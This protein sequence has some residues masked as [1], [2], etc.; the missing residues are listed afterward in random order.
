MGITRET[1]EKNNP[2]QYKTNATATAKN[3]MNIQ[4]GKTSNLVGFKWLHWPNWRIELAAFVWRPFKSKRWM[5]FFGVCAAKT[6][7]QPK[8]KQYELKRVPSH[9]FNSIA[10]IE[11]P[12][13]HSIVHLSCVAFSAFNFNFFFHPRKLGLLRAISR[14][15]YHFKT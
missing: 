1:R 15:L 6:N 14:A 11:S 2:K 10:F 5:W 3:K 7:S 8:E 9:H 13:R 12:S 4:H